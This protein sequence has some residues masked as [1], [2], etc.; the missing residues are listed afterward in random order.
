MLKYHIKYY[1][2]G[3]TNSSVP[4]TCLTCQPAVDPDL[5]LQ[6]E[7]ES[8]LNNTLLIHHKCGYS[9]IIFSPGFKFYIQECLGADIPVTF[10]V[11]T[12]TSYRVA[13]LDSYSSLRR[14]L[15]KLALPQIKQFAIDIDGKYKAQVRLYY[16]PGLREY[17]EITFP[18]ILLL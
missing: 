8:S 12:S 18:L 5:L 2:S 3:D 15:S 13:V 14:Q 6:L 1:I 17:E 9:N 7:N 11:E 10:L 4:W 16:P